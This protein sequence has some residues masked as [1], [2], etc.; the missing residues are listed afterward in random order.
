MKSKPIIGITTNER[1]NPNDDIPWSYAPTGFVEG[2]KKAGG[3]PLLFPIGKIED[4]KPYISMVD[5]VLLIGGQNVDP[6]FYHEVNQASDN[7]FLRRRDDFEFAIIDEAIRQEKP[8]FS[9]CR[10]TQLMNVALGGSLNQAIE[11]HWQDKPSDYLYHDMAVKDHTRL[12]EIYGTQ[13]SIN[14][15]HHQSIKEL[16]PF[17]DVIAEDPNDQ[18]IE[19]VESNHPDIHFMGVQWHPELLIGNRKADQELFNY[20]V[21][22]L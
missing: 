3:L 11:N 6:D 13:S 7:D 1:P 8:I 17:L 14:S 20:F 22:E 9:V 16:S 18:T 21:N 4:A 10:G 19:A 15:F 5:K 2:V 12:A